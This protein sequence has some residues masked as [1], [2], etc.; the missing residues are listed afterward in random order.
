MLNDYERVELLE[1]RCKA[2]SEAV[3]KASDEIKSS[4]LSMSKPKAEYRES[5]AATFM[6]WLDRYIDNRVALQGAHRDL[7]DERIKQRDADMVKCATATPAAGSA[8]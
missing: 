7:R 1:L 4:L 3:N 5:S 8:T 2:A 6:F